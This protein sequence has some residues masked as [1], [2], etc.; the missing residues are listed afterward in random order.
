MHS[1]WLSPEVLE[2]PSYSTGGSEPEVALQRSYEI[3]GHAEKVLGNA[4]TE[5]EL[6]D[7]ITTLKRSID[8]RIR[9]LNR[10]YCF[11]QIPIRN[12]PSDPLSLLELFGIVRPLMFHNLV[13]IRNAVEHEDVPPPDVKGTQVFLEFAWYFLKSTDRLLQVVSKSVEFNAPEKGQNG[14]YW[15]ELEYGPE[16]KWD[17]SIR[18][19]VRSDMISHDPVGN[20]IVLSP[21]SLEEHL[22]KRFDI[23]VP[24]LD[25]DSNRMT[26]PNDS[27]IL[28]NVRGPEN[29]LLRLTNRYFSAE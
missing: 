8:V 23:E 26:R 25:D 18:G 22:K 14:R 12:K 13:E 28:A 24:S 27:Y 9:T 15:L 10:I 3:W 5:L 21:T 11:G 20:W 19:W 17:P 29:V 6:V 16:A 7:V 2:W 4:T 1:L